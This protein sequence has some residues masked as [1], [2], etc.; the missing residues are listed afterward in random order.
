MMT[1]STDF[2]ELPEAA[3][4]STFFLL[5][6]FLQTRLSNRLGELWLSVF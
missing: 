2:S 5:S 1:I 3:L 6:P 4:N